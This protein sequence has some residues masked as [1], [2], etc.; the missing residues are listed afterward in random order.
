MSTGKP[1]VICLWTAREGNHAHPSGAV[2]QS[3][4][5]ESSCEA[6]P[7][8]SPEVCLKTLVPSDKPASL[9]PQSQEHTSTTTQRCSNIC[10][11]L[12]V[13]KLLMYINTR[14]SNILSV[15]LNMANTVSCIKSCFKSKI[16]LCSL[17]R[18]FGGPTQQLPSS[19]QEQCR[20]QEK[21]QSILCQNCCVSTLWQARY[22]RAHLVIFMAMQSSPC[23]FLRI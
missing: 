10:Q 23:R 22:S 16:I 15:Y 20:M 17:N 14:Y 12:T 6:T 3:E 4:R 21:L 18:S 7:N 8:G 1:S 9:P 19:P 5:T 11:L 13:R 2:T